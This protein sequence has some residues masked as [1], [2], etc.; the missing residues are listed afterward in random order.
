M[1]TNYKSLVTP[2]P[3]IQGVESSKPAAAITPAECQKYQSIYQAQKPGANGLS[4]EAV[5]NL[6]SKSKLPNE[7]LAQ[8]W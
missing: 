8:I 2:L 4:A 7:K 3:R 6:L 5:Q 1:Y